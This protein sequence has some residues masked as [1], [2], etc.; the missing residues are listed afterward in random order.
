M[1]PDFQDTLKV[2]KRLKEATQ[3]LHGLVD[4]VALARQVKEFSSDQ[5]KALLARYMAPL[6]DNRAQGTAEALA[7]ASDEYKSELEKLERQYQ[8]AEHLIAKWQAT[9]ASFE[10]ARSLLSMS[11]E[12][13]K[14]LQG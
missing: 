14:T 1:T 2:E 11:K 7:R 5:R 9:F 8:H 10:A 6:L 4:G 12:T 3:Q 13:M